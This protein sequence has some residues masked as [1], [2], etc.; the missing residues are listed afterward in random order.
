[1]KINKA[2]ISASLAI[3]GLVFTSNA[4]ALPGF[5]KPAPMSSVELCVV[6]IGEQGGKGLVETGNQVFLQVV[7]RAVRVPTVSVRRVPEDRDES[8]ARF[9]HAAAH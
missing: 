2:V 5:S 3:A 9:D 6:Q 7:A 8:A 1:M 4:F